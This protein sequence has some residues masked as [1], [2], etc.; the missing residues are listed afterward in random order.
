M[1]D[2]RGAEEEAEWDNEIPEGSVGEDDRLKEYWAK[3]ERRRSSFDKYLI[4]DGLGLSENQR[5]VL[6]LIKCGEP[7]RDLAVARVAAVEIL[8]ITHTSASRCNCSR[9]LHYYYEPSIY[10]ALLC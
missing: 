5:I 1:A 2:W 7:L 3:K 4:G 8:P 9:T 6:Y 10:T